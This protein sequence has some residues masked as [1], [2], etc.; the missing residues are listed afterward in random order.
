VPVNLFKIE[1]EDIVR[2]KLTGVFVDD[3]DK[4]LKFYT[5]VLGFVKHRFSQRINRHV[6]SL[7]LYF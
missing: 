6:T 5:M 4:A 1:F 2:I 7:Q 3:R